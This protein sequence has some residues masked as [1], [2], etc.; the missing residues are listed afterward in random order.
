MRAVRQLA[1]NVARSTSAVVLAVLL[2]R[3]LFVSTESTAHI[4]TRAATPPNVVLKAQV[5]ETYGRLP[6]SF[7]ANLGQ[8]D[9]RVKFL[10][11][12]LGYTLFLTPTEAVL[13]LT[14]ERT[15]ELAAPNT[16]KFEKPQELRRNTLRMRI[17]GANPRAQVEGRD[18]LPGKTHYFLGNDPARWRTNVPTYA[19]VH[20]QAIYPGIDLMYYGNQRQLEY[21]FAVKPGAEPGRIVLHFEGAQ[22]LEVDAGGDLVIHTGAGPIHQRR[23]VVYQEIHGTR[24]AVA[25]GYILRGRQEVGFQ[26]AAYD[27]SRPLIIDP[28]LVY[29]TYLGGSASDQGLGIAVDAA[30]SAYVTGLTLSTDFPTTP[31]AFDTTRNGD[32]DAFVTKLD[33]TGSALLFST[34]L[35]GSAQDV[36]GG[37]VVDTAGNAYVT[38]WTFS[39]AF[40]TTPGAFDTSPNGDFDAFVTKLDATGS[41]LLYSTYLGGSGQDLGSSIGVDTAGNTYLTGS[42]RSTNFPTT[43][44]SFDTTLTG[45]ADAYVT[46]LNAIGS[47]PLVYSTYLG[48]NDVD[49]GIGIALDAAGNAY[50]TGLTF[51]TDFATPGAFDTTV[52]GGGDAYV[53]KLNAIGSAPLLYSTYLGGSS[54][55]WGLGIAVDAAG[56]AYV[57]GRT[58]SL[59]FPTTPGAF[60]TTFNGVIDA[61]VTKLNAT[62]SAPLLY[63]TYLGGSAQD[64]GFG[65]ALDAAGNAYAIG[66]TFSGDFP[67]TPGMDTS[68]NGGSDVYVTKLDVTGSAPLLYSTYL[69]GS[70]FEFGFGIAVDAAGNAYVT[71]ATGSANFPTTPGAFDVTFN[72][73]EDVFVTKISD[74]VG[75]PATLVLSPAADTNT[76]GQQHCVTATVKDAFGNPVP[77]VTVRFAVSG[78]N[79]A[80]GSETTDVNG[81]ATFCYKGTNA[82]VDA[83]SAYADTNNDNTQDLDEPTGAAT[84]TYTPG[85]AATVTVTPL[86]DTNTVGTQ[87]CVTATVRDAFGNPVSSVTVRFSV[88]G[89]NTASGS[90]TTN[91][92]GE[93]NFCY[94]GTNVGTD[95]IQAF[96]D[97]DNDGVHDAG[98]PS[99]AAT[100]IYV[101]RAPATVTMNPAADTNPVDSQHCVTATVRD[102]LGNPTPGIVVRF[103]VT[104]SVS[105]SGS[106]TTNAAGQATFCYIGPPLPGVDTISAFA[107]TD[108]D[109]T[110]DIGE[111]SGAATKAWVFPVTTPLCEITITNGGRITALNGDQATFGGNAK[112]DAVGNT[113]GQEQYQDHGPAQPLNVHSIN[114]LAIVCDGPGQE[115]SIY[116]QTTI[117]GAGSFFYRIKV[118]D[119]GEPGVE[120]DKYWILLQTGYTSGEQTLEGGNVQISRQ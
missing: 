90:T 80:G 50:L 85:P 91:A 113:Q 6:L 77:G 118:K 15:P 4:A 22:R 16:G 74:V 72:G 70:S 7:E 34:Y 49:E 63:S 31:G 95:T 26:V 65:I 81:E 14:G 67:T 71:G 2:G 102:A 9:P 47:A 43:P 28:V 29:S 21:D 88:S 108:N 27:E 30:G 3:A 100:K 93:A 17:V 114:V 57:H 68:L 115:A 119:L 82:G 19:K 45:G 111:P 86:T 75:P 62:G 42:T 25:G 104:G 60:D 33:A 23:P 39:T 96:A 56:N 87:H 59:N 58:A 24:Q 1:A 69:G 48:G 37:I 54:F 66:R 120:F 92:S 97:T 117:N 112:S 11:R 110:Q 41:A 10:A 79:A 20:H 76:V 84:K 105:A 98:E 8:T 51:S 32:F 61:F 53:T 103:T 40:P 18:K 106:T 13:T 38:G 109:G 94:I 83:I 55:E 73:G 35:G 46:K 36:G 44:G 78:A 52:N 101:P 99:G 12:G 64:E 89:A 107:D 5:S 116:G